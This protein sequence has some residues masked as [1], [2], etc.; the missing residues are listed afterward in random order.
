MATKKATAAE[1]LI[2]RQVQ[3][4][5]ETINVSLTKATVDRLKAYCEFLESDRGYVVE[6]CIVRVLDA[7]KA[8]AQHVAAQQTPA[9]VAAKA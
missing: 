1:P 7:D 6:A 5:K 2:R 8:F 4:A 3:E 9:K